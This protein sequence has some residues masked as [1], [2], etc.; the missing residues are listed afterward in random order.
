M[1]IKIFFFFFKNKKFNFSSD[2]KFKSGKIRIKPEI[3][4]GSLTLGICE[5]WNNCFCTDFSSKKK[6]IKIK[7]LFFKKIRTRNLKLENQKNPHKKSFIFERFLLT[8]SG[9]SSVSLGTIIN[10]SQ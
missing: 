7:N 4:P 5:N 6:E 9:G 1:K 3:L 2:K 8:H 10:S